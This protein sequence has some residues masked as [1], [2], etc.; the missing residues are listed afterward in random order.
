MN[1]NPTPDEMLALLEAEEQLEPIGPEPGVI[2]E[3]EAREAREEEDAAGGM[4]PHTKESAAELEGVDQFLPQ[5]HRGEILN[6]RG[7]FF[8]VLHP[9]NANGHMVLQPVGPSKKLVKRIRHKIENQTKG[10]A[11]VETRDRKRATRKMARQ[12]R[13]LRRHTKRVAARRA[14]EKAQAGE[15]VSA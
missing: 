2:A 6:W 3:R 9:S 7:W 4:R 1:R 10:L 12:K 15:K 13:A 14:A 5:F 8:Q 11:K